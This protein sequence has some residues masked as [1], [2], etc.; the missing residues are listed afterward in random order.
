MSTAGYFE[1]IIPLP[2][3]G[4]TAHNTG[5]YRKKAPLVKEYRSTV[6]QLVSVKERLRIARG[7]IP[8]K[9]R[10]HHTWYCAKN[11]IE[12]ALGG[13]AP[14]SHKHY[15][16]ADEGNAI[17]ALKPA[18]DGLVDAGLLVDDRAKYVTYGDFNALRTEEEHRGR[19][20]IVLRIEIL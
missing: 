13:K 15:R 19:S 12:K 1:I 2:P 5:H 18:I 14:K 8:A 16:P 7:P 17:Q 3:A 6:A 11:V 10:I 9:V 4:V 20:H